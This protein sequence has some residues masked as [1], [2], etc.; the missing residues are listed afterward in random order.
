[1]GNGFWQH[2]IVRLLM[3]AQYYSNTEVS[4]V[5]ALVLTITC[6][7]DIHNQVLP[8]FIYP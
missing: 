7:P 4:T 8:V 5:D 1:M 3:L 2:V 6:A